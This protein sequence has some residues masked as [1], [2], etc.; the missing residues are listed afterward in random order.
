MN[1][2]LKFL[3]IAL[4]GVRWLR[5]RRQT[6]QTQV[7]VTPPRRSWDARNVRPIRKP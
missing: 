5:N 4:A 1:R 2:F 6:A 3:P 7:P